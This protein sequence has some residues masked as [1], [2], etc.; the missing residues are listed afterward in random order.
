MP[1]PEP[2]AD[3]VFSSRLELGEAADRYFARNEVAANE[4]TFGILTR[5]M[6]SREEAFVRSLIH[7]LAPFY[8]FA[9]YL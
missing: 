2:L 6:V 7:A 1:L 5:M 9:L 3:L 4:G 8:N